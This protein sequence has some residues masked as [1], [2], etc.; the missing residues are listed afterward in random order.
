[1]DNWI[2]LRLPQGLKP[3]LLSSG[4]TAEAVPFPKRFSGRPLKPPLS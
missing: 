4:G 3:L 1:M 2:Q